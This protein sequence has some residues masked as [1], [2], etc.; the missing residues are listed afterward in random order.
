MRA[1]LYSLTL[2]HPSQAA[3]LMLERKGIGHKVVNILPGFQPMVVRLVG[4]RGITVPALPDLLAQ[5][6]ALIADGTIGGDDPNAADFQI[7][8][9]V[10]VLLAFEDLRPLTE[11]HPVASLARRILPDYPDPIPAFLPRDWLPA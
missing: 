3:R 10:H 8:T 7:A 11:R 5:A 1:R 9:A 2:S 4:F 6:D